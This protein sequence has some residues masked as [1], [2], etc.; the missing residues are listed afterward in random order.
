[1]TKLTDTA[2]KKAKPS[3]SGGVCKLTDGGGLQLWALPTGSKLWRLDYRFGGKRKTF[4]IGAYPAVSLAMAR[5]ARDD[6][7]ALLAGGIDP[8]QARK[9][10]RR[11]RAVAQ[12]NSFETVARQWYEGWRGDK[13][14][15]HAAYTLRR[16]EKNVFP[17]LGARPVGAIVAVELVKMVKG[18]ADRGVLDI[19]KRSYETCG[20][21]LRYAVAHSL[22]DRNPAA[23][24]KLEDFLPTREKKNQAR[25]E[26]KD[27]PEL[28]RRI[29]GYD[30]RQVTRLAMKLMAL[31]F[32][33]TS[34]LIGARWEEFDFDKRRWT[35][36]AERMKMKEKHI[37]PLST[38]AL[39][40]LE[41]LR[42]VSGHS[43][44]LFPGERDHDKPMSNNT[45]L[46]ALQRMGYKG[47]MT[48]HGF[49]GVAATI[50]NEHGFNRDHVDRQLAHAERNA[51][52]AAYN[53][54]EY[55]EP[56]TRMMQWW[57]D[58]TEGKSRNNVIQMPLRRVA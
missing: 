57:G 1:M 27:F 30:G 49:R 29:E 50:L 7:R 47:R 28:L 25:V 6:A 53:H 40:V 18:I 23:D 43:P 54:A 9:G 55:L 26:E 32:V 3:E 10:E 15:R 13:S 19:A 16:L 24:V 4:S 31:T 39:E 34:E 35:I 48:G 51:V 20:Q 17:V 52:S 37:V 12:E 45:I 21:I 46:M 56:R 33:R 2:I 5:K 44:L 42:N 58:Y 8:V 11:E 38:Q 36:P 41:V 22:A 14:P